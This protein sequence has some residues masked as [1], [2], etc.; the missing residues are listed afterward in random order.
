MRGGFIPGDRRESSKFHAHQTPSR[1]FAM[2][3]YFQALS[4]LQASAQAGLSISPMTAVW[5]ERG[6]APAFQQA[7]CGDRE[8]LPLVRAANTGISAVVDPSAISLPRCLWCRRVFD[9]GLPQ[10]LPPTPMPGSAMSR[11]PGG[12]YSLV[13][14]LRL[15]RR[16]HLKKTANL[17]CRI[18]KSATCCPMRTVPFCDSRMIINLDECPSVSHQSFQMRTKIFNRPGQHAPCCV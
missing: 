10:P 8:G 17:I 5:L 13:V 16:S 2:R 3:S 9:S 7:S 12:R 11:R 15:R 1:W 4:C 18:G 14:V 6:S